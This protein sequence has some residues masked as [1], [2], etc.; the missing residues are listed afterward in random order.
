MTT[1][2]NLAV[3]NAKA[4]LNLSRDITLKMIDGIPADKACHRALP[5]T[6]HAIWVL[7]HAAT[8][9]DYFRTT[10]GESQ[11]RVTDASWDGLFGGGSTPSDDPSGYP[12]LDELKNKAEESRT[13]FVKWYE[14]LSEEQLT[15]P[16][17]EGYEFFAPNH[18]GLA[19]SVA[20][21]EGL[22]AGQLSAIRRDLGLPN[23]M[24][25]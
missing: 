3:E 4:V 24:G 5:N 23:A 15:Q 6:N 11:T 13:A 7:G 12:T 25:M 20:W 10:L 17:P 19:N 2:A 22:H 18:A 8:T 16:L 14:S 1:T 9:D 21:H